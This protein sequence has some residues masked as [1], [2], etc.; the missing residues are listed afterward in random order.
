MKQRFN[1]LLSQVLGILLVPAADAASFDCAKA[2]T[3]VEVSI[4]Q[5]PVLDK[6]DVELSKLYARRMQYAGSERDSVMTAQRRWLR[7]DRNRCND[8]QCIALSIWQQIGILRTTLERS[9]IKT[10][11]VHKVAAIAQDLENLVSNRSQVVVDKTPSTK[12]SSSPAS[13]PKASRDAQRPS[14]KSAPPIYG[15]SRNEYPLPAHTAQGITVDMRTSNPARPSF[16]VSNRTDLAAAML[17]VRCAS[18]AR[19]D[20]T[21]NYDL[22][23]GQEDAP[24]PELFM[25]PESETSRVFVMEKGRRVTTESA[26]APPPWTQG[27]SVTCKPLL[28]VLPSKREVSALNAFLKEQH[29][30]RRNAY[31]TE[32]S[33]YADPV[34]VLAQAAYLISPSDRRCGYLREEFVTRASIA[35]VQAK[36]FG[37]DVARKGAY[38]YIQIAKVGRCLPESFP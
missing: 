17:R 18:V 11:D 12:E 37:V 24:L 16:T 20:F 9:G 32:M 13:A 35:K 10:A 7:E 15:E 30:R 25:L 36:H 38:E 4:C 19:P 29:E 28:A 3:P 33:K 22:V 1:V 26:S 8:E 14:D 27:E 23:I 6:L 34:S 2:T 31:R 5:T 21:R